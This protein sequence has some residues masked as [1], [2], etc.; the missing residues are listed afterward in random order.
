MPKANKVIASTQY[1]DIGKSFLYLDLLQA[2]FL[3]SIQESPDLS[4]NLSI[5]P[6]R[7]TPPKWC[8]GF[9][10]NADGWLSIICRYA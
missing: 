5:F 4:A 9:W 2:K 7:A 1:A 10:E 8:K 3:G 6:V